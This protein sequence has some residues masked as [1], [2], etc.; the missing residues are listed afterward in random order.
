MVATCPFTTTRVVTSLRT[1]RSSAPQGQAPHLYL[2]LEITA[3]RDVVSSSLIECIVRR[4]MKVD[5][6]SA[7]PRPLTDRTLQNNAAESLEAC[8]KYCTGYTYFGTEYG[9]EVSFLS[10]QKRID[11]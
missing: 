11:I 6:D 8:A 5:L 9:Q 4:L 7:N 3:I 1:V 10:F 2:Q